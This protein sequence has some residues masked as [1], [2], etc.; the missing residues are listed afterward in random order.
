VDVR[1]DV[2]QHV[3]DRPSYGGFTAAGLS[4]E[5][6]R[7]PTHQ[8]KGDAINGLDFGYLPAEKSTVYRKVYMKVVD[9]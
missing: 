2:L 5:S 8:V 9:L 1:R 4:Y 6:Q 7:L 3:D